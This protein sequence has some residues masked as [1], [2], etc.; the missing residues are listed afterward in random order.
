[1]SEILEFVIHA[2]G[3]VEETVHGVKG[4]QC[5]ALTEALE[6]KLGKVVQRQ[7]TAEQYEQS[8]QT[9]QQTWG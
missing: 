9:E 7:A 3:R 4:D 1:M 5:L 6:D 2:D 8:V